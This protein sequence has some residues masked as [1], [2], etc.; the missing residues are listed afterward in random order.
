MLGFRVGTWSCSTAASIVSLLA[1]ATVANMFLS[2]YFQSSSNYFSYSPVR[3]SCS[4][5]N[6]TVENS[7]QDTDF[8]AQFVTDN[9]SAV[10][11]RGAPWKAEIGRW[12]SGCDSVSKNVEIDE[13]SDPFPL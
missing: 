6:A 9:F 10:F 3:N 8:V 2:P 5:S 7:E 12:L 11:H 13:V 4:S 1:F